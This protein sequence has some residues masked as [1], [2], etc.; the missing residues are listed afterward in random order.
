MTTF[1]Q[2]LRSVTFFSTTILYDSSTGPLFGGAAVLHCVHK[3]CND[4]F[5]HIFAP[6]TPSQE[7][8]QAGSQALSKKMVSVSESQ[9]IQARQFQSLA[10][11]GKMAVTGNV[12][13]AILRDFVRLVSN[14]F[15][16]CTAFVVAA[17]DSALH[18]SE[19]TIEPLMYPAVR[20]FKDDADGSFWATVHDVAS[21]TDTPYLVNSF[22]TR[23][24]F[25][26]LLSQRNPN[27]SSPLDPSIYPKT[28]VLLRMS[29][30][31][32]RQ[33]ALCCGF[34]GDSNFTVAVESFLISMTD[35]CISSL[36]RLHAE[37]QLALSE[38]QLRHIWS[39][40]KEAMI[41]F[42]DD[43]RV[44]DC[45][46]AA[47]ELMG[48][49]QNIWQVGNQM[50]GFDDLRGSKDVSRFCARAEE[51][52]NHPVSLIGS[53]DGPKSTSSVDSPIMLNLSL[54]HVHVASPPRSVHIL[55]L[56]DISEF[57]R[58]REYEEQISKLKH[59]GAARAKSLR[60]QPSH[61]NS[62]IPFRVFLARHRF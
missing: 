46:P 7:V 21:S 33:L 53:T 38:Q 48:K 9:D 27:P 11:F 6:S 22:G 25:D 37:N 49:V 62:R 23:K 61:T 8:H 29:K 41:V 47:E 28:S 2:Q 18:S 15:R 16:S 34:H 14:G 36:D 60:C 45:N 56:R 51:L 31:S 30:R 39:S 52:E 58:R 1:Q 20:S 5:L 59:E 55:M 42:G 24:L 57:Q 13:H 43:G 17:D 4:E 32:G 44:T 35:L 19:A 10:T 54:S 3:L 26:I 12:R 50:S 40:V